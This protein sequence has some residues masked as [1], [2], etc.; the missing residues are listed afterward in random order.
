MWNKVSV[1]RNNADCCITFFYDRS[2][3]YDAS[4]RDQNQNINH[5]A[6]DQCL[7]CCHLF[8]RQDKM[9]ELTWTENNV[10]RYFHVLSQFIKGQRGNNGELSMNLL[11]SF[12]LFFI[13]VCTGYASIIGKFLM[14]FQPFPARKRKSCL[15]TFTVFFLFRAS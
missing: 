3:L 14:K 13:I 15:F 7:S 12:F 2:N 9:K 4:E 6:L 11:T 10:I 8:S 5:V 1:L